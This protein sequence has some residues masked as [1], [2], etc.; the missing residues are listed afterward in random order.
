MQFLDGRESG[1]PR[2]RLVPERT[3]GGSYMLR[4]YGRR[5]GKSGGTGI[6]TRSH[7]RRRKMN[8]RWKQWITACFWARLGLIRPMSIFKASTTGAERSS[9][10][11]RLPEYD[12]VHIDPRFRRKETDRGGARGMWSERRNKGRPDF[13]DD[14]WGNAGTLTFVFPSTAGL[15]L[16]RL[17][18]GQGGCKLVYWCITG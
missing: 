11:R 17:S 18:Q 5:R 8:R 16:R 14:G 3:G 6:G 1:S 10:S 7:S 15:P 9:I 12:A 13:E 2:R 4:G